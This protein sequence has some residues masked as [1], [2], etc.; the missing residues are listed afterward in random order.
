M[1][2]SDCLQPCLDHPDRDELTAAAE[3]SE[4]ILRRHPNHPRALHLLGMFASENGQQEV[5]AV[6]LARAVKSD[7]ENTDC[8]VDLGVVFARMGRWPDAVRC[9]KLALNRKPQDAGAWLR[10][11]RALAAEGDIEGAEGSFR[12]A[13]ALAPEDAAAHNSLGSML[14]LLGR[15][16]ASADAF[17]EAVRIEPGQKDHHLELANSLLLAGEVERAA[18]SYSRALGLDSR[19]AVAHF[20]Q[21]VCLMRLGRV[22]EAEGS[23]REAAVI[24][25]D[26]AEAHNNYGILRQAAGMRGEAMEAY[27][28]ALQASPNYSEAR[29]NLALAFQDEDLP[30]EA[31]GHYR[32]LIESGC[33]T[34]EIW[35]NLGNCATALMDLREAR[36][37]YQAAIEDPLGEV[38]ARWNLGLLDLVEGDYPR[39]WEGYE[40]RFRQ[41]NA[42][43]R[44][45]EQPRWLGGPLEGRRI[46]VWAE[47]GLGDTLQFARFLSLVSRHGGRVTLECP[48]TLTRLLRRTAGVEGVVAFGAPLPEFDVHSPLMSLPLAL[49]VTLNNLPEHTPYIVCPEEASAH[50]AG[51]PATALP[52]VGLVW[53][54]NP[55]HR[56]DRNR[57][58]PPEELRA[59]AGLDGLVFV[60]LQKGPPPPETGLEMLDL[61]SRLVDVADTAAV[62]DNLDLVISVDTAVAHLAGALGKPV[63]TL[64]PH[65]PDWRWLL[66]RK[67]SPWY[68]TMRLFRQPA[69]KDWASVMRGVR[70]DLCAW[71]DAQAV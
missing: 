47:Q 36:Q 42:F 45:F 26:Y 22:E 20:N 13:S 24:Q 51:E 29:Y 30:A 64:L 18:N 21:G 23:F 2:P 15:F 31:A 12:S 58:L 65:A 53:T 6:L 28:R 8:M 69:R 17:A 14:Q 10:L 61:S 27:R 38:E 40:W 41:Q 54:G 32:E 56:N 62:I 19:C 70:N 33:Q 44:Q 49:E 52:R 35:N 48:P 5:A 66:D 67:D 11:G 46:L 4:R 50:W 16:P 71:R 63:W 57:S 9:Y 25:P 3:A 39:G 1:P 68:P 59:L 55:G 60:S 34:G 7:S 43:R 37:C